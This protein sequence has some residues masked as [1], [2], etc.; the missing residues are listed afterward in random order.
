MPSSLYFVEPSGA[1]LSLRDA[2]ES[3]RAADAYVLRP[4]E[5]NELARLDEPL[6]PDDAMR[7]VNLLLQYP[8]F[9]PPL[10]RDVRNSLLIAVARTSLRDDLP[11]EI[12]VTLSVLGAADLASLVARVPEEPPFST[13]ERERIEV[14][15]DYLLDF[16]VLAK[17]ALQLVVS[18]LAAW[19]RRPDLDAV[20]VFIAP[21][22]EDDDRLRA[23]IP[24]G[25]D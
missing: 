16:A 18:A 9:E 25:D 15:M 19:P 11:H 8:A 6:L 22:L 23:N 1:P 5:A 3:W 14:T 17:E 13:N 12:A 24:Q 4:P 10:A 21:M 20:K 7:L 2:H